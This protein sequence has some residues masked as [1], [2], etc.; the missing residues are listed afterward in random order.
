VK[1]SDYIVEFLIRQGITHVFGYPGGMVTHL[2]DS[3]DRYCGEI[4]AHVNYHEQASAMAA[5]GWAEITGLPGVAYATSGPG[6]TNLLTGI[7]C[8]YFDSLPCIFITGQ[9][10]TYEQKGDLGI[11]QRGFQETDIVPMAQPI[12]KL[13]FAVRSSQELPAALETAYRT[14]VEGRP[15]PVLLDIPMDVFRGELDEKPS[16]VLAT[17]EAFAPEDAERLALQLLTE[18]QAAK[19]PVILGG[20]GVHSSRAEKAFLELIQATG[21]PVVTSMTAVDLAPG[22]WPEF[23][24]MIGAYGARPANYITS[25]SDCILSLGSRLDCRQTGVARERFAPRAK[26]LRVDIDPSELASPVHKGQVACPAPLQALLPALAHRARSLT[27]NNTD[28]VCRCHE[29]RRI[30]SNADKK[31]PGAAALEQLSSLWPEGAVI[32]T[33]VGQNQVWAAQS[34]QVKSRQRILFS[35]G[36]GAMGYSLP[37]ATGAALASGG[38]VFCVCGDGGFQMNIQELQ[39]IARERLPVKIILLNNRALGMIHHFQEMYFDSNYTQTTEEKGYAVPNFR[40]I[41]RAYGIR[42]VSPQAENLAAVFSD[43][44]PA[45]L[46][47][48]LPQ[49][50]YVF[51]KLGVNRPIHL[52]EPPLPTELQKELDQICGWEEDEL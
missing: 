16:S 44:E 17:S 31:E 48:S 6:A 40:N 25:Y 46:E 37:A 35:G 51:P 1:A 5:C 19:R 21:I 26:V 23:Y 39:F 20:H 10:N 45:F 8:A 36:M 2:M 43:R 24:G 18:L 11:R 41:V 3:L 30:L 50:T 47:I 38:P 29:I 9:V 22:S 32:T 4:H 27:W 15:G 7:A 52:Q 14:A 12:T 33:D 28:W 49:N 42:V 34:I 13:S